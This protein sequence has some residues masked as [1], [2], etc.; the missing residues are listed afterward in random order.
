MNQLFSTFY[1]THFCFFGIHKH[2]CWVLLMIQYMYFYKTLIFK[3][4]NVLLS[5]Q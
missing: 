4:F 3:I 1:P 5:L 2:Y